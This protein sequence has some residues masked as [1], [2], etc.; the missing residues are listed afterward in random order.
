MEVWVLFIL[1]QQPGAAPVELEPQS[2]YDSY[3][4]CRQAGI[5]A[6]AR[7]GDKV[8]ALPPPPVSIQCLPRPIKLEGDFGSR[9]G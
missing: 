4:E 6:I 5:A 3:E 7:L 9:P 1:L 8:I 2:M